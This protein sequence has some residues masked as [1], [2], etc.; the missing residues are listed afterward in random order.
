MQGMGLTEDL[1]RRKTEREDLKRQQRLIEQEQ[2]RIEIQKQ[3]EKLA[4]EQRLKVLA[5][6]A[7]IRF[8]ESGLLELITE[9]S[10]LG[11][12]SPWNFKNDTKG[13]YECGIIISSK[14][15]PDKYWTGD[16]TGDGVIERKI[17]RVEI[18]S[19]GAMQFEGGRSGSSTVKQDVWERDKSILEKALGKAYYNPKLERERYYRPSPTERSGM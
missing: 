13:V 14:K 2:R 8:Q 10:E 12:G 6:E 17:V 16:E 7:N 18:D 11:G 5:E 1:R 9:V 3:E 19:K 15:I 4:R